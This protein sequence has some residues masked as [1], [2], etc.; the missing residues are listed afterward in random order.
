VPRRVMQTRVSRGLVAALLAV[1]A[2]ATAGRVPGRPDPADAGVICSKTWVGREAD[3]EAYLRSASA[4]R[5]EDIGI[6]VTKPKRVFFKGDGI[7]RS[8][9]WKPIRPGLQGGFYESYQSEIA[10]YEIDKLLQM[11][12]V[13][14]AVERRIEGNLGA[15]IMWVEDVKGW[16]IT[17]P[18]QGPDVAA[19]NRQVIA[20]KMFD[21]LIGN[22][23]RNQ[24]NLLYDAEYHLIL[25]DHSRAFT[26]STRLPSPVVRVWRDLYDRMN[27]LTLEQLQARLGGLMGRGQIKAII[28]RR[29]K[30]RREVETLV[31]SRGAVATFVN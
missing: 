1:A 11:H 14:P 10:A 17:D 20:M 3:Y 31:S 5:I 21:N 23:D 27:A 9:A 12:M 29:D 8:A 25:I 28:E 30:L 2:T 13:P 22:I 26:T 15:L 24:G 18:V 16:K 4:D 7:I 19:W 6:G